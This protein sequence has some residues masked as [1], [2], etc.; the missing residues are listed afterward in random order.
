MNAAPLD[1]ITPRLRL[2]QLRPED[3]EPFSAMN[4]DPMVMEFSPRVLSR[5]ESQAILI[6]IVD[7]FQRRG[8]GVYAVEAQG[9]FAGVV[10][11]SVP[12]FQAY[13]T[14]C[15]EILWR[16]ARSFWGRGLASEAAAAVLTGF[17]EPGIARGSRLYGDG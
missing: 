16:L 8:F 12:K 13:F 5:E 2:R 14:P 17:S 9:E 6:R 11:L 7:G 15:V 4:A 10:G 1:I 3:A